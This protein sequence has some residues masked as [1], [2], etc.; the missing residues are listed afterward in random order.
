MSLSS[1]F[2]SFENLDILLRLDCL[3]HSDIL[4]SNSSLIFVSE[5][6]FPSDLKGSLPKDFFR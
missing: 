2:T 5:S 3:E 4:D 6:I 1:S